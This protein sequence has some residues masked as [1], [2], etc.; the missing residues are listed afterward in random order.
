LAMFMAMSFEGVGCF[1]AIGSLSKEL[2]PRANLA[3]GLA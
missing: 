1:L 2:R 3:K